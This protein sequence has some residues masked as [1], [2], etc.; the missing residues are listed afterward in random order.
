[1]RVEDKRAIL[2]LSTIMS[3]RMVGL[4]MV[5]PLFSLYAATLQ[6]ARPML[7]G[8]S[9]GVYGLTQALFQFPFGALS[10]HINRK[11]VIGFGLFIFIIGSLLAGAAH[12]I[13][14]LII[15]RGLQGVGAIGS[16]ILALLADLTTEENRTKAMAVNGM[17]IGLSFGI[18]MMLG[19]WLNQWLSIHQLFFLSAGFGLIGLLLL[20]F[21]VPTPTSHQWHGDTE[22]AIR[23]LKH[24]LIHPI[25]L[26]LNAGIFLLHAIF[27]ASFV[28]IPLSLFQNAHLASNK[29]WIIYLPAL[30]IGFIVSLVCIGIAEAKKI[31]RPFFIAGIVTLLCAE[32]L[33]MVMGYTLMGLS[34]ALCFFFTGFSLLEAFL[35]SLISRIAPKNQKGSAMGLYSSAQFLGIFA[36]GVLGGWFYGHVGLISVYFLSIL[37]SLLWLFLAKSSPIT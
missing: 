17:M 14:T 1:M 18:A 35:P 23:S 37:L 11:L 31:I 20:Y 4:F 19:P 6:G 13:T 12:N 36:G 22:P 30:F 25:L 29:Q 16:T 10:D 9:I 26:R 28:V 15:A 2:T 21:C 3:L 32:T 27:T 7:I 5:L 33:F 24:L 34:I 8:I